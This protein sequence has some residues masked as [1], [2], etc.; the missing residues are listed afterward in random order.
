MNRAERRLVSKHK[1]YPSQIKPD[2]EEELLIARQYVEDQM[3]LAKE[4]GTTLKL[5]ETDFIKRLQEAT[6][7]VT[8]STVAAV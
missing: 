3:A 7:A 4:N 8:E 6:N 2:S 5:S 1:L